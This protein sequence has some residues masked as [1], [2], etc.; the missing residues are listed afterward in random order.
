LR[1][2]AENSFAPSLPARKRVSAFFAGGEGK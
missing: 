2:N 1:L